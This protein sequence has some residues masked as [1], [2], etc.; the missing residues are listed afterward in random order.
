[1]PMPHRLDKI[2]RTTFDAFVRL[3][4]KAFDNA[5]IRIASRENQ[6]AFDE[7]TRLDPVVSSSILFFVDDTLP[8]IGEAQKELGEQLHSPS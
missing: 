7:M 8:Q 1:M 2:H 4:G 5:F 3:D 6:T